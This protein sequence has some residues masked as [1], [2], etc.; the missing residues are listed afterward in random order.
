MPPILSATT[1][2]LAPA[3]IISAAVRIF[4]ASE[5]IKQGRPAIVVTT[6][7]DRMKCMLEMNGLEEQLNDMV[8]EF[9]ARPPPPA[10]MPSVIHALARAALSVPA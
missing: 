3:A 4:A 7:L 8:H 10:A 6:V 1:W 2:S 5:Q 9:A